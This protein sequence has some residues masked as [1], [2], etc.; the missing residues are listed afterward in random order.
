MTRIT[1]SP[2]AVLTHLFTTGGLALA[3]ATAV[4]GGA[5]AAGGGG[6]GGGESGPIKSCPRGQIFDGRTGQCIKQSSTTIDDTSRYTYGSWLAR[7]GRYGEAIEVLSLVENKDDPR[8]LNY[9]GYA[10]RQ[11]GRFEVGLGFYRQALAADPDYVKAREYLGEAYLVLDRPALA[12]EQLREIGMRCG[13]GCEEYALLAEA[14][15]DD[16][17]ARARRS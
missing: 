12:R 15:A 6:G 16:D 9:L 13:T 1:Q 5:I 4:P 2:R 11:L 10:N 7:T 17:R 14:I 8:V 3:V